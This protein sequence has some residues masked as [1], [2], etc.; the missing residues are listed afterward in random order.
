MALET[1]PRC[2]PTTSVIVDWLDEWSHAAIPQRRSDAAYRCLQ[3]SEA[4]DKLH[5]LL[6]VT[7]S[8]TFSLNI[9]SVPRCFCVI[10]SLKWMKVVFFFF[11]MGCLCFAS[12]GS[13]V[14]DHPVLNKLL[15][16]DQTIFLFDWKLVR[17]REGWAR[18]CI[19]KCS[20]PAD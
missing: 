2:F 5:I 12:P 8:A 10:L 6:H 19:S 3:G 1:G 4:E 7:T 18:G 15:W 17:T 16:F 9:T 13:R 11:L 14:W 20:E